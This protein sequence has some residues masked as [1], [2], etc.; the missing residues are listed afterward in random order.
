MMRHGLML[1]KTGTL[2]I[3]EQ[4]TKMGRRSVLHILIDGEAGRDGID[5]GGYVTPVA[6]GTMTI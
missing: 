4:G 5:V 2:R 1:T 3:S 6:T